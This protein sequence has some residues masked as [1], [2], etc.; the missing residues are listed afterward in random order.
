MKILL[1]TSSIIGSIASPIFNAIE[2]PNSITSPSSYETSLTRTANND[3]EITYTN[4][5]GGSIRYYKIVLNYLIELSAI[6]D[7]IHGS[8][9]SFFTLPLE[10]FNYEPNANMGSATLSISWEANQ[11]QVNY[12]LTNET[13]LFAPDTLFALHPVNSIYFLPSMSYLTYDIITFTFIIPTYDEYAQPGYN[14]FDTIKNN[15][16]SF[17]YYNYYGF[18]DHL[19]IENTPLPPVDDGGFFDG[20]FD[21][22]EKGFNSITSILNIRLFANITLGTLLFMPLLFA[23]AYTLIKFLIGGG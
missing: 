10:F 8:N 15:G 19:Q 9:I 13:S 12:D 18:I 1:L 6:E 5:G 21:L 2:I 4:S 14:D 7:Q 20:L 22:L 11:E 23:I 17:W 3:K 16:Y